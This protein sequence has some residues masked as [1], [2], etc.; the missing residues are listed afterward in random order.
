[1]SKSKS[2]KISELNLEG[3]LLDFV[4]E[5]DKATAGELT[6]PKCLRLAT[7]EGECLIKLS[8]QLQATLNVPLVLGDW[9]QVIGEKRLDA[10]T[11]KLK[12]KAK[13]VIPAASSQPETVLPNKITPVTTTILVCQKSDC[14]KRGGKAV[15][16]ALQTA[17]SDRGLADRVAVKLTG[18]MK[19]CSSGPNLIMPD[20][21]RHSRVKAAQIPELLDKYFPDVSST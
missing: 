21:T 4:F 17:L 6:L 13:K 7:A 1:M 8:K 2:K 20:K 5:D 15:C 3:R 19:K 14:I 18:C 9:V 10:K 16:Q 12:L 11:G